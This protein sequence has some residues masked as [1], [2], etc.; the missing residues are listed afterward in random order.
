MRVWDILL[1]I[2]L[3]LVDILVCVV[4]VFGITEMIRTYENFNFVLAFGII[5]YA[6]VGIFIILVAWFAIKI[7]INKL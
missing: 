2:L 4:F 5:L 6:L 7:I 3:L 1:G